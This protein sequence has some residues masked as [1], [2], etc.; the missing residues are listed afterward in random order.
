MSRGPR[1]RAIITSANFLIDSESQLQAAA[2]SFQPPAPGAG[3]NAAPSPNQANIDF[4]SNPNPPHKGE[5]IFDVR[6]TDAKGVTVSGAQV[7]ATLVRESHTGLHG[8]H[9][10]GWNSCQVKM[11]CP[12]AWTKTL[13]VGSSSILAI[14]LVPVLMVLLIRGKLRPERDNPVSRVTQAIYLPILK[15]CLRHRVLT[16]LGNVIFLVITFPLALHLGS[17][18]MP[19][20][21]EDSMLYMPTSLPGISIGQAK[22]LPQKQDCALRSFPEVMG[23]FGTVGRSNSTTSCRIWSKSSDS[24]GPAPAAKN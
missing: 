17:Q 13:A 5:N 23:V 2:G 6:L 4:T 19:A 7:T 22:M 12:L 1:S 16:V 18:F 11:F 24:S 3:A 20:L 8:R 9:T 14:T 15:F 21:F 10:H